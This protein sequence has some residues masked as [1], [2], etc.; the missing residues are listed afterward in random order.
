[1]TTKLETSNSMSP[2]HRRRSR[3]RS[4]AWSQDA[5]DCGTGTNSGHDPIVNS[6]SKVRKWRRSGRPVPNMVHV[7][8]LAILGHSQNKSENSFI[9]ANPTPAANVRFRASVNA[10]QVR[11]GTI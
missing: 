5:R 7:G 3:R 11:E 10:C 9:K 6:R 8:V 4:N 1:M 2:K